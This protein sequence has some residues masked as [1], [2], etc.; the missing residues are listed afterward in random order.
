MLVQGYT[1]P[2]A[3][4]YSKVMSQ[5][6]K[7]CSHC[8]QHL[9]L[10]QFPVRQNKAMGVCSDCYRI[11]YGDPS[12]VEA[13]RL[14]KAKLVTKRRRDRCRAYLGNMLQFAACTDCGLVDPIV[15][16]F[17]HRE[18]TSKHKDISTLLA[19]GALELLKKELMKCDIVCANC[20]RRRSSK[21]YGY[22]RENISK[23]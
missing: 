4:S 16:E 11:Y 18:P 20:H 2:Q 14:E 9:N 10:D 8:T 23:A 15:M 21:M 13:K 17:D 7:F 22:W 3:L 12:L 1:G 6:T 19:E 5:I